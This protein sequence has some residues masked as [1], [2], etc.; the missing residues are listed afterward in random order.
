V[1]VCGAVSRDVSAVFQPDDLVAVQAGCI[2]DAETIAMAVTRSGEI[3][4][5]VVV[6]WLEAGGRLMTEYNRTDEV[7]NAVFGTAVAQG[8]PHG[9]GCGDNINPGFRLNQ[10]DPFWQINGGLPL[11]AEGG[12]GFDVS[13]FPGIVPLGGWNEGTVSLA[14]RDIGVGRFWL[15]EADWQDNQDS[16]TAASAA[17]MRAILLGLDGAIPEGIQQ[18]VPEADI[19][20][21]GWRQCY[22]GLYG[23]TEPLGPILAACDGGQMMLACRRVGE[24]DFVLAAGGL[25]AEVTRDVGNGINAVNNH[26]GVDFYYSP[27][28]SWGFAPQG[29]G[30][31]RTS[32]D[33]QGDQSELRMCW[34]TGNNDIQGGY[35][36]GD[37][38]LNNNNNWER[39]IFVRGN[40]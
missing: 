6:P 23:G 7:F 12:C 17:L 30:V 20:G 8:P 5:A 38:F 3:D 4:P 34:H 14:Y 29:V 28:H 13:A 19:L 11:G 1:L 26:N 31:S 16:F 9:G 39:V 2:P 25:T 36:C 27:V 37:A 32:C 35:R 10:D 40:S 24:P 33:T 21:D 18:N 15:V 22:R